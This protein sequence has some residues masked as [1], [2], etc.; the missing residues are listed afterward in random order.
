MYLPSSCCFV[1]FL[2]TIRTNYGPNI[3]FPTSFKYFYFQDLKILRFW[4]LGL[5]TV[6]TYFF[7]HLPNISTFSILTF[8]DFEHACLPNISDFKIFSKKKGTYAL[9]QLCS[10]LV[11]PFFPSENGRNLI[12]SKHL[13]IWFYLKIKH[14]HRRNV[15]SHH[16]FRPS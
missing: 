2:R 7:Q 14:C 13:E 5:T 4:A 10:H 6:P 1:N 12:P 3:L 16:F 11:P 9:S 8:K 15:T